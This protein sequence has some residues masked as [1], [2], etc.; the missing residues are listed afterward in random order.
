VAGRDGDGLAE[1]RPRRAGHL[2]KRRGWSAR[3]A[4]PG[5]I[6]A[7]ALAAPAAGARAA[8]GEVALRQ[9][10]RWHGSTLLLDQSATTQTV[11]V[12]S[13]YQSANPTYEW[14]LAVK[15]QYY[16]Y[17]TER[18]SLRV[19][20]WLNAYLE[21]TDSDSTTRARELLLGPT[22]LSASYAQTLRERDGYRTAFAVGPRFT[23]PTDKAAWSSGQVVGAGATGEVSQ[24][25]PLRGKDAR[26]FTGARLA[27][28]AIYNHAF[29]RATSPVDGDLRQLRQ[30]IAGRPIVSDQLRGQMN[31]RDALTVLGSATLQ[32][33]RR[34]DVGASYV[35][36]S[37]WVYTPPAACVQ[38]LTG[39][40]APVSADAT[41]YRVSTWLTASLGYQLW[42]RLGVN[43]GYYNRASQI[44]ADG[45][46]RNPLW[47]PSARFFLTLVG[48]L[49]SLGGG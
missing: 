11:G 2:L 49:D 7:L 23:L 14:W 24:T 17:E 1:H 19:G 10:P 36:T 37:S 39:C 18:R 41:A 9:K 5:S 29:D 32:I 48:N 43:V 12:G 4:A 22:Y 46:R 33:T 8:D 30:D 40:A 42:D 26:A 25:F 35:V 20:M 45:A 16:L 21:I 27:L 38:T 6:V 31:V 47:S 44:G 15:P 28:G 34:F 13:D 3:L